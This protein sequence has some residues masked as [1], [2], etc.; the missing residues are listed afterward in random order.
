MSLLGVIGGFVG[1][2]VGGPAGVAIGAGVGD[3]AGGGSGGAGTPATQSIKVTT[4]GGDLT[5]VFTGKGSVYSSAQ[6]IFWGWAQAGHLDW[7]RSISTT[8]SGPKWD[9]P[10]QQFSG[11]GASDRAFAGQLVTAYQGSASVLS[12]ASSSAAPAQATGGAPSI[13]D[14]L[15]RALTVGGTAAAAELTG[16]GSAALAQAT[17]NLKGTQAQASIFGS[18]TPGKVVGLGVVVAVL[19]LVFV[20]IAKKV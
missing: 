6:Y 2:V 19:I 8:G 15:G 1:G 7:L 10:A 18:L 3:A 12:Q 4:P 16:T 11:Y 5:I 9:A 14:T 17:A 20:W 13:L